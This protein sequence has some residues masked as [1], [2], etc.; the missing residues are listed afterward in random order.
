MNNQ[1][2][3]RVII[4]IIFTTVVLGAITLPQLLVE[5]QTTSPSISPEDE[6]QFEATLEIENS[7]GTGQP[8]TLEF[9]VLSFSWGV[10][11][12]KGEGSSE[13]K[14]LTVTKK[15]DEHSSDLFQACAAGFYFTQATLRVSISDGPEQVEILEWE[16]VPVNIYNYDIQ[17]D[18]T[19][20]NSPLELITLY[21]PAISFTTKWYDPDGT[22]IGSDIET[23][24]FLAARPIR[25]P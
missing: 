6:N 18:E 10:I 23:W 11:S 1:I 22:I 4:L 24:D 15:V 2:K 8:I 3:N 19:V 20:K 12:G 17:A 13:Q 5:P 21:F 9:E 14:L 16:M 7:E 25:K